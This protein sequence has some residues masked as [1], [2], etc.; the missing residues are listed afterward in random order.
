MMAERLLRVAEVASR[1]DMH[2]ETVRVWLR[3]GKLRG[4]RMGGDKLG[5]R[6]PESEIERVTAPKPKP[7]PTGRPS[8]R[9]GVRAND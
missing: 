7:R 3:D 8:S 1:L 2:E 9:W 4:V 6:I 5:W